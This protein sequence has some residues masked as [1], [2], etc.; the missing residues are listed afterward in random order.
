MRPSLAYSDV[1]H[2]TDYTPEQLHLMAALN[3]AHIDY[4]SQHCIETD[5]W[6]P[7]CQCLKRFRPDIFIKGFLI[8]EVDGPVHFHG[9]N[10]ER[11]MKRDAWLRSR[12]YRI[13]RFTNERVMQETDAV[14]GEIRAEMGR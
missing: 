9:K 6:A 3:R 5:I 12:G 13:V 7:S 4:D 8:V 2:A 11:D 1:R 10:P 14:V